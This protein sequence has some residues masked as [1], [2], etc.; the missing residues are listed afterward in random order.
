[1][2]PFVFLRLSVTFV[3]C[4]L[5]AEDIDMIS[6]AYDLLDRISALPLQ[7]LPQSD[8][9]LCWFERRRHSMANC[10][11]MVRD[12]AMFIIE[13]LQETTIALLIGIF[14]DPLRPPLPQAYWVNK[15]PPMICRISNGHISA[16]GHPIHIMFCS[17]AGPRRF[18]G[19]SDRMALFP[20]RSNPRR[21]Q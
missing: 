7:T 20:I 3:H 16:K 2:L 10:C 5:T 6:F 1:M 13:S 17:M 21:R 4:V 8:P 11:R 9:L 19:S 18:S 14:D 15:V 12:S